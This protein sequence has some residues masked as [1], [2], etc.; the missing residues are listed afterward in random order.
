RASEEAREGLSAFLEK[1]KP[2]WVR[3]DPGKDRCPRAP[4]EDRLAA[5]PFASVRGAGGSGAPGGGRDRCGGR[6]RNGRNGRH[7][8]QRRPPGGLVLDLVLA[9]VALDLHAGGRVGPPR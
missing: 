7:G 8:R 2:A 9:E 5:A 3:E 1:R 4:R 6:G